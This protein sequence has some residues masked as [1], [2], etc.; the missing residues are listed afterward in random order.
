[1]NQKAN[2]VADLAAVLHHLQIG[3]DEKRQH[4][5]EVN[6]RRWDHLV[7]MGATRK[8]GKQTGPL[9]VGTEHKGVE[10]VRL[11]WN[12]LFDAEFAKKWPQEVVHGSLSRSGFTIAWPV[13]EPPVTQEEEEEI[14]TADERAKVEQ[15]EA[16]KNAS[17]YQRTKRRIFG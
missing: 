2:S 6:K 14:I 3:P 10:G 1:M 15:V 16:E 17:L 5:Y 8:M 7:Q 11:Y 12:E 13:R 9:D 4:R